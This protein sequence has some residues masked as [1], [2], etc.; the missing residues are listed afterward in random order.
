[1]AFIFTR[2]LEDLDPHLDRRQTQELIDDL[3]DPSFGRGDVLLI[4]RS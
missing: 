1:M 3:H 2:L 4:S